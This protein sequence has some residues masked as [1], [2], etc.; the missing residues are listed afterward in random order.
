MPG[1]HGATAPRRPARRAAP[2]AHGV[3][4]CSRCR[5]GTCSRS[6]TAAARRASTSSTCATSRPPR[7]PPRAGRRSRASPGVAALTAG[8]GRHER[9]E[10]DGLRAAEPLA[11]GGAR[12]PRAGDALGPGLAAG[13]RPRAVR[14]RR[15]PSS[16]R[17]AESTAEIPGL[18]RRGA[19]ASRCAALGGPAFV[20]FPLDHVFMRGPDDGEPRRRCPTA[21]CREPDGDG[22]RSAPR[23][24]ARGRAAGDHGRHGPLLGARRGRAAGAG[25]G[26]ADPGVP[27][28]PRRAAACP[29][30]TSSFFSR[31][32]G[33]RR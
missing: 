7:S 17:H 1:R 6:T 13:D 18:G 26:A 12:R 24:A 20:D 25:R 9:D 31:A 19:R 16:P 4:R 8:P 30:T 22:A 33:R 10:R 3:T 11:D 15:W 32:R 2:A 21:R 29:P 27:Q 23:A 28:R 14:A 5:A